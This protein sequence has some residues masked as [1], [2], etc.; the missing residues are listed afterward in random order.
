MGL[1]IFFE[2]M[3]PFLVPPLGGIFG[4]AIGYMLHKP[5]M[6]VTGGILGGTAGGWIGVS[7]YRLLYLPSGTPS[8]IVFSAS[9]LIGVFIGSP[10]IALVIA[11][12][13][14]KQ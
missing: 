3:L 11:R 9:V 2:F 13:N 5:R 8:L 14:S 7:L 1:E 4:W 10:V 6:A 12:R